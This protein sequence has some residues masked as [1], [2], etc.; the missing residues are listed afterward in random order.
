[1]F[2]WF[3]GENG[4][5]MRWNILYHVTYHD[6]QSIGFEFHKI[7]FVI[8]IQVMILFFNQMAYVH[9]IWW[10]V[11]LKNS[12]VDKIFSN[13]IFY[14]I[15]TPMN[16]ENMYKITFRLITEAPQFFGLKPSLFV[17]TIPTCT[18]KLTAYDIC[19]RQINFLLCVS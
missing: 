3:N 4:Q 15:W 14:L 12:W 7:F 17:S 16:I 18:M 1:M 5:K 19:F 10:S 13:E 2:I 9:I 8:L 11:L 6:Y